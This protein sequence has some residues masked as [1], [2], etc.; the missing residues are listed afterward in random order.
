MVYG[1]IIS[2][3]A[4]HSTYAHRESKAKEEPLDPLQ[5]IPSLNSGSMKSR[6]PNIHFEI[7]FPVSLGIPPFFELLKAL[8][9]RE[10][11]MVVPPCFN[12]K[13]KLKVRSSIKDRSAPSLVA[14]VSK[15]LK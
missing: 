5:H 11:N 14:R 6:K 4:Q 2:V 1:K 7:T 13:T 15:G 9:V 3:L 12:I 8:P 10:S